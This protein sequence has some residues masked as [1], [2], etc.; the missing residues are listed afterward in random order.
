[1]MIDGLKQ[2][3]E[4]RPFKA[5]VMRLTNGRRLVVHHPEFLAR[6]PSGRTVT[7]YSLDESAETIDLLHVV[8]ISAANGKR[9]A[10]G[11]NGRKLR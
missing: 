4:A 9:K 3:H 8:S 2:W 11:G 5:F 6:S 7:L 10:Q 1:M